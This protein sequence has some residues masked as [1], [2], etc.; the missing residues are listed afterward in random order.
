LYYKYT[1]GKAYIPIGLYTIGYFDLSGNLNETYNN[2]TPQTAI[3]NTSAYYIGVNGYVFSPEGPFS[4]FYLAEFG[5]VDIH[6]T[7]TTPQTASDYT[8]LYYTYLSGIATI[9]GD[10]PYSNFYLS[11]GAINRLYTNASPQ[12]AINNGLYYTYLS[13]I[14][15][16]TQGAYSNHYFVSGSISATYTNTTPQTAIDNGIYY[17]YNNGIP[18]QRSFTL[19]N[20]AFRTPYTFYCDGPLEVGK[21]L[22]IDLE[23]NDPVTALIGWYSYINNDNIIDSIWTGLDNSGLIEEIR[24]GTSRT[25]SGTTYYYMSSYPYLNNFEYLYTDNTML[26]PASGLDIIADFNNDGVDDRLVTDNFGA[27]TLTTSSV[28]SGIRYYYSANDQ[29]INDYTQLFTDFELTIPAAD[30]DIIGDFNNDLVEEQLTTDI[31]GYVT[32]NIL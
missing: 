13:G 31:D 21:T 22:Y 15:S 12:T 29:Y 1:N 6:Y 30:L 10:G 4:N 24:Y 2:L 5:L 9:V 25:L 18:I 3:D 16:L 28:L 11:A 14:A 27:I 20:D 8:N 7:N 32:I 26:I 17:T 19:L 23:L